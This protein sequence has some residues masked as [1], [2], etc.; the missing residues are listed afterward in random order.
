MK[1]EIF[2]PDF[3]LRVKK[4]SV[5]ICKRFCSSLVGRSEQSALTYFAIFSVLQFGL[6][7]KRAN[8]ESPAI[9]GI[10]DQIS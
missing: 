10:Y 8:F 3:A 4:E 1:Y 6:K 7:K 2:F 9:R 5:S